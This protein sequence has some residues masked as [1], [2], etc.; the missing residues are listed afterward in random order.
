MTCKTYR[1]APIFLINNKIM[2]N[3]LYFLI[4]MVFTSCIEPSSTVTYYNLM[5]NSNHKMKLKMYRNGK[6]NDTLVLKINASKE[7]RF[8]SGAGD[9]QSFHYPFGD[10]V[11]VFFDDTIRITHGSN[12]TIVDR[13]IT[14]QK[15]YTGGRTDEYEYRYEFIFTNDDYQEALDNQ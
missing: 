15:S 14:K 8:I 3:L 11:Y 9:F 5:N 1:F 7:Y 2:K 13:D 6:V 4:L 12:N 10:S